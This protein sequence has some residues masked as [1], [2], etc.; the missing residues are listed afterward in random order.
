[1]SVRFLKVVNFKNDVI[2]F[3]NKVAS[4]AKLGQL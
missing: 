3:A 2:D 4:S 1:M